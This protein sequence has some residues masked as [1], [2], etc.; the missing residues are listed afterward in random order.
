[1]TYS[2]QAKQ[3]AL[4]AAVSCIRHTNF[5]IAKNDVR[6]IKLVREV[7]LETAR[8]YETYLMEKE[9]VNHAG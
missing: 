5:G 6:G 1:M 4:Q 2:E 9:C 8:Q 3:V 7:I